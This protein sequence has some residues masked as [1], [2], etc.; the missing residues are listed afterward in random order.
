MDTQEEI[1]QIGNLVYI[2]LNGEVLE[3]CII[4]EVDNMFFVD[5]ED[6]SYTVISEDN[7]YGIIEVRSQE[8]CEE[9]YENLVNTFNVCRERNL[10]YS[11]RIS[12]N[13]LNCDLLS[14]ESA[15]YY[16]YL[17]NNLEDLFEGEDYLGLYENSEVSYY[18]FKLC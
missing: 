13:S 14:L 11:N 18:I 17:L 10:P 9:I 3:D 7:L 16:Y 5:I 4:R 1:N 2:Y 6:K 12:I 8:I 15:I